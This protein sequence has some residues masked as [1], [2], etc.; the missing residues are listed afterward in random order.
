MTDKELTAEEWSRIILEDS[1]AQIPR[2]MVPLFD[3]SEDKNRNWNY[4]KRIGPA[5]Y[6]RDVLAVCILG[7]TRDEALIM[8]AMNDG[9][10]WTAEDDYNIVDLFCTNIVPA[11]AP[12]LLF[13]TAGIDPIRYP[14][15][16]VKEERWK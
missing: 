4:I 1:D 15:K 9:M 7:L 16:D 14:I 5:L 3:L 12:P 10:H 8:E 2:S 11:G 13:K 6:L